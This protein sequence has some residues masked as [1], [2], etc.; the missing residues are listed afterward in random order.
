MG[1]CRF[2]GYFLFTTPS[3]L[4]YKFTP[5]YRLMKVRLEVAACWIRCG[6]VASRSLCQFQLRNPGSMLSA[7]RLL[8]QFFNS[9]DDFLGLAHDVANLCFN[10]GAAEG[11]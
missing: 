1:P 6:K 10:F 11:F 3:L 9:L 7:V 4:I 5:K 8:D 2:T